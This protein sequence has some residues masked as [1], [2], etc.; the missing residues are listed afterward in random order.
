MQVSTK[1]KLKRSLKRVRR[2]ATPEQVAL[3][4]PQAAKIVGKSERA[5]WLDIYRGRFPYRR[6][7]KRKIVIIKE[8]LLTYLKSLPGVGVEEA[9]EKV[10]DAC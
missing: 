10:S 2:D 7:G 1:E 3:T 4:V 5:I 6:Q 9:V 8:E